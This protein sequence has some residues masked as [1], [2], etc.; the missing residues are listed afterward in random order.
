MIDNGTMGKTIATVLLRALAFTVP[1]MAISA[2]L[3]LRD[4]R[5]MQVTMRDATDLME[6]LRWRWISNG[7]LSFLGSACTFAIMR[8]RLPVIFAAVI[9]G[10]V[11]EFASYFALKALS[12][13][14]LFQIP[15]EYV[16]ASW[17]IAGAALFAYAAAATTVLDSE[18][19]TITDIGRGRLVVLST[20]VSLVLFPLIWGLYRILFV[21]LFHPLMLVSG[22]VFAAPYA[23]AGGLLFGLMVAAVPAEAVARIQGSSRANRVLFPLAPGLVAA[24]LACI[25]AHTL[26]RS[27]TWNSFDAFAGALFKFGLLLNSELL[28]VCMLV[29]LVGSPILWNLTARARLARASGATASAKPPESPPAAPPIAGTRRLRGLKIFGYSLLVLVPLLCLFLILFPPSGYEAM[30][31]RIYGET[32]GGTA[33]DKRLHGPGSAC[34]RNE[35]IRLETYIRSGIPCRLPSGELDVPKIDPDL[36]NSRRDGNGACLVEF[37]IATGSPQGLSMLLKS[38]ADP[39]KCPG[40]ADPLFALFLQRSRNGGYYDFA[41]ALH[42]AGFRPSDKKEFLFEAA[43]VGSAPGVSYV[44]LRVGQAIDVTDADGRTPLYH[45][46]L[47]APTVESFGTVRK[48]IE[49]GA[50]PDHAGADGESPMAKGRRLYANTKWERVFEHEVSYQLNLSRPGFKPSKPGSLPKTQEPHS[51]K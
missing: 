43:R 22:F 29:G 1:V 26:M 39:K 13:A 46:I 48:L 44:V 37:A 7:A 34:A 28:L 45:A 47:Q 36:A 33:V 50:D 6:Y 12:A 17:W 25:V 19:S 27:L 41:Y 16:H 23:A 18:R 21:S 32:L 51:P 5:E 4:V 15:I 40:S 20:L 10:L 42:D 35:T 49:L 9:A 8:A 11:F 38:G 30:I 31:A 2:L 24:I 3:D 14:L